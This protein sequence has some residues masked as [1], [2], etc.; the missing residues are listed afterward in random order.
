MRSLND[1]PNSAANPLPSD[2]IKPV[3]AIDTKLFPATRRPFSAAET[4]FF[5]AVRED[6]PGLGS[7][8]G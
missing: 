3:Q 5:P 4:G 1:L 8:Q 7:L 2:S 6:P